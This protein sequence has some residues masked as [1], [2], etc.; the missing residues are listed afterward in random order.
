MTE[1]I[2][3]PNCG[4]QLEIPPD[5]RGKRVRCASCQTVFDANPGGEYLPTVEPK[6]SRGPS[7]SQAD[8]DRPPPPVGSNLRVWFLLGLTAF[9]V[10]GCV[11]TC[12]GTFF[13]LMNPKMH[14]YTADPAYKIEL[15]GEPTEL[16][17]LNDGDNPIAGIQATREGQDDHYVVRH[18]KVPAKFKKKDPQATLDAL[19][20]DELAAVGGGVEDRREQTKYKGH[21]ALDIEASQT[22]AKG[23]QKFAE[24]HTIVRLILVDDHVF[25]LAVQGHSAD[26][27]KLW[28]VQKFFLSFEV[29]DAKAKPKKKVED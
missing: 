14:A 24:M 1:S 4:E 27:A 29:L 25:V 3:C 26:L 16:S 11:L 20:K 8:D 13:G 2:S 9:V 15:P 21:V 10:S 12:A 6:A 22:G 18:Y 23:L 17:L 5:F 19:V 28:W 7:R